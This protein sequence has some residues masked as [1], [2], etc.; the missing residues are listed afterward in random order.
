MSTSEQGM[1][2]LNRESALN[3]LMPR[4]RD[5]G[6]AASDIRDG[7]LAWQLWSLLGWQ[8]IRQ[9]YRRSTIGPFWLTI[10]MSI[11]ILA[12]SVV[13]GALFQTETAAFVPYLTTSL[14]LWT[15]ISTVLNEGGMVF[16]GAAGYIKQIR[17][18]HFTYVMWL[19]WRN[20]LVF[21]HNFVVYPFVVIALGVPIGASLGWLLLGLPLLVVNLAWLALILGLASTRFRDIPAMVQ[22]ALTILFF[23]T[24][25]FWKA[26]QLP[27]E[28]AY[29][30]AI[31]PIT[32]LID[33]V[34]DPLLGH[35]PNSVSLLATGLL[36]LVGWTV[37][38]AI[39]SR[40]RA[41]VSYWL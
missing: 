19:L 16:I 37:T 6:L 14:I 2:P 10:T 35:P 17:R 27:P 32:H 41:R 4:W 8:D 11:N 18:P 15:L 36:A 28:R 25:I 33:V 12:I 20:L 29:I 7:L 1:R 38:F 39:F 5:V 26:D 31:N 22:S 34:R 40:F 21:L 3:A 23:V 9:R 24:P 30:A 13:W